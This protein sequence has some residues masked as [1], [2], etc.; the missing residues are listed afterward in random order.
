MTAADRRFRPLW[1]SYYHYRN[2][3]MVY[4]MA[5]GWLFW[6]ALLAVLPKWLLKT[7]HHRGERATYLRLL[8]RAVRDGLQRRV[9]VPHARVLGW[10]QG[11]R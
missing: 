1:K 10:V 7:G 9:D 4:R 8:A 6:P 5:A 11:R 3:L 2:L